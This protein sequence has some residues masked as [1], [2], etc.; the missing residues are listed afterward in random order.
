MACSQVRGVVAILIGCACFAAGTLVTKRLLGSFSPLPL[1]FLQ[2]S[3]SCVAVWGAAVTTGRLPS[4]SRAPRL[5]L[6]GLLQPG[7]AYILVYLGLKTTPVTIEGLLIALETA[8]VVLLAWPLLGERPRA[9]TVFAA[10]IATLGVVMISGVGRHGTAS[11]PP[12]LGVV[13]ILAGV[14]AASLDTIVSRALAIDADPLAMTAASH[15]AGLALVAATIPAWPSDSLDHVT[16]FGL[17]TGIIVSGLL[18]HG[19]ATLL[20]NIGLG[21]VQ[22]NVAASLFPVMSLTTAA[23]GMVWF[24][25]RLSLCQL[26]GG[27]LILSAA[28]AVAISQSAREADLPSS[29]PR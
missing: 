11:S 25:E 23:G 22:A 21:S 2:L 14:V 26:A 8:F 13:L 27:A 10:L 28:A 15:A 1:V 19:L 5:A 4:P 29:L 17:L 6:P 7:L 20:F 16:D 18:M 3:A 12:L 24:S 9:T